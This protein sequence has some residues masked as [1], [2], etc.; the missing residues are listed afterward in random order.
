VASI[1]GQ[2]VLVNHGVVVEPTLTLAAVDMS[3]GH[4]QFEGSETVVGDVKAGMKIQAAGD[5]TIGGVVE[6]AE[7]RADGDITIKGGIIGHGEW[8]E[9]V[10]AHVDTARIVSG[11]SVHT[12]FAE[13]A[14]IEAAGCI[15]AEAGRGRGLHRRPEGVRR[16]QGAR[17]RP[18]QRDRGRARRRRVPVGR[19]PLMRP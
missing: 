8:S 5:V 13:N 12:R 6:A 14:W 17:G 11:G 16:Q 2:P 1:T 19:R 10:A 9:A 15:S 3:T 18:A 7:I 4:I